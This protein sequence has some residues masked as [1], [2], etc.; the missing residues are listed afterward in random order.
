M[1][2][3]GNT[4]INDTQIN[5]MGKHTL[6]THRLIKAN[7]FRPLESNDSIVNRN[8]QQLLLL[9]NTLGLIITY[10]GRKGDSLGRFTYCSPLSSN[11]VAYAVTDP[12]HINYSTVRPQ[13]PLSEHSHITLSYK[14]ISS[15]TGKQTLSSPNSISVSVN[16]R[17]NLITKIQIENMKYTFY[18]FESLYRGGNEIL[19]RTRKLHLYI[20]SSLGV[21][22]LAQGLLHTW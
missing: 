19:R 18:G 8:G 1:K 10:G 11:V 2:S 20:R 7:N 6:M 16:I 22:C 13:I 5:Q 9:C 3:N 15:E 4:Y 12:S 14:Q 21:Q 17:L